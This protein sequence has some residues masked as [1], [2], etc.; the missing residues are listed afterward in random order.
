[1]TIL[2][3]GSAAGRHDGRWHDSVHARRQ[4]ICA[5]VCS[6]IMPL[7]TTNIEWAQMTWNP[8]VGCTRV[9][10]GC[11]NCYAFKLHD[12]R[13]VA[14]R[15][16]ANLP[17]Q[18]DLPFSTVQLLPDRLEKPLRRRKP[19]RYFVNSMSDLFHDAVD[20]AFLD[21]VFEVMRNTPRHQYLILTKR[22]ERMRD[23]IEARY[24]VREMHSAHPKQAWAPELQNVWL[25]VSVEDQ[26]TTETRIPIL[27][28]MPSPVRFLSVEPL[29]AAVDL[30]P[31]VRSLEWV[32]VGGESGP[33]ARPMDGT[34]VRTLRA[35]CL[36]SRVA[37]FFKQWG[38]YDDNGDRVGRR[39]AG[40]LLD[41][42]LWDTY[43]DAPLRL[44]L[45]H[46]QGA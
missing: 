15:G 7:V 3:I 22:P 36:A 18:Y 33:R 25:G 40:R 32:I 23:Y 39:R 35:Q 41:G 31:Y 11:T 1:M 38:E 19:T 16:G 37:F 44:A 9:S 6:A 2:I 5:H 27:T 21:D 17:A 29:L 12:Q 20:D 45:A 10:A 30:L 43:P 14:K 8:T 42:R 28:S 24:G 46:P 26:E 34:W 13:Y 4:I